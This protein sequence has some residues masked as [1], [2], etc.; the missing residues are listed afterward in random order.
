MSGEIVHVCISDGGI[1]KR[2]VASVAVTEVGLD[3]DRHNHK[4]HS[5]L[6]RAVLIQDIELL[7]EM[8]SDGFPVEPGALGENLTVRGLHVQKMNAGDRLQIDD[9]GPTLELTEPRKPCFQLDPL[10]DDMQ[11]GA[12]GRSGFLARVLAN[13][14]VKPGQKIRVLANEA[15]PSA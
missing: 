8:R 9:G 11:A 2:P 7:D 6:H 10:H 12:K 14:N 5:Q 15:Q 1:P 13:G 3:G 4:K